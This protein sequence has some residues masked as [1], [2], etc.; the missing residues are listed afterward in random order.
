MLRILTNNIGY[1]SQNTKKAIL[2]ATESVE[3]KGFRIIV[4]ET[5]QEV[6]SGKAV[7]ADPVARWNK[8]D[9]YVM[10]FSDF[11]PD[12]DENYSLFYKIQVNTDK[13][14]IESDPFEIYGNVIEFSTLSSVMYNFK[15]QRAT[16][17]YEVIDRN[18]SFKG[19]REGTIDVHGGWYDATGDVG[20]HLTH[21]SVSG[22]FGV[23]Q[24]NIAVFIFYKMIELTEQSSRDYY[25]I[26]NRRILDEA[27]YGADWLMRR[28][29]PSG[30]FFKTGPIR[31]P[32]AYEPSRV[33]RKCGFEY[34]IPGQKFGQQVHVDENSVIKYENYEASLRG[35][36]GYAAAALAMAA[37][38]PYPSAEHTAM[39]YLDAARDVFLYLEKNNEKY[40]VNHKWDLMDE[41]SA[42]EACNELY[43]TSHE[44]G[45]MSRARKYAE[46]VENHYVEMAPDCGYLSH[47]ETDRPFFS[48]AEEGAPVIALLN[49][50][51][52]ERN[53]DKKEK[54]LDI[55]ERV[56][57]FQL[58]IT[59]E[60]SNP[61]GYAREYIQDR[62]GNR[63]T[64]FFF[65]HHTEDAPWWQGENA[66]ILSLS[67]AARMLADKTADKKLAAA[68]REYADDQIAWVLGCNPFDACMMEGRGHHNIDYYYKNRYDFIAA[69][70][71]IVNGITSAL[72]DEEGIAYI[73]S[74][75]DDEEIADNWRWAEQWIPHAAWYLYAL[76]LKKL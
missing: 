29:A 54:A 37:R 52:I 31:L 26:F 15:S 66:R 58:Q 10:N 13:G 75:H 23:Q 32:D 48:P 55:A 21:Q 63:R 24:G 62:D 12:S 45:F 69:P 59:H 56:M 61:F 40:N 18:L 57:R 17:E 35:G 27:T 28:R 65:P 11:C 49:Y 44:F 67:A 70:G 43:K 2:Q 22:Y 72:D 50:Y 42:L 36:A 25:A 8:G 47:D 38:N 76:S 64:Q 20:V 6:F 34:R 68:L 71:G 4:E 1:D 9:Y 33:T 30:T 53:V 41:Y 73:M 5:G 14:T 74:P 46:M 7:K 16:G 3:V 39:E 60:T 51:E 19:P